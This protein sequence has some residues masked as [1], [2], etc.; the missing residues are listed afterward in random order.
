MEPGSSSERN[1]DSG[2]K[3]KHRGLNLF[4]RKPVSSAK[5]TALEQVTQRGSGVS[6]PDGI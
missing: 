2:H 4:I 6:I 1:S 3:L 5:V